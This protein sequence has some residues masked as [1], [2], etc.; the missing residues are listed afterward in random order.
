[1]ARRRAL[2]CLSEFLL[3]EIPISEYRRVFNAG[4]GFWGLQACATD[5]RA[6][7]FRR[8]PIYGIFCLA[9][10]DLSG[11]DLAGVDLAE[12]GAAPA[13]ANG[14]CG[15]R[16]INFSPAAA[17]LSSNSGTMM[18]WRLPFEPSIMVTIRLPGGADTGTASDIETSVTPAV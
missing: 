1:M 3:A 9:G 15:E 2:S 5:A 7:R 18:F 6:P 4:L 16:S 17:F 12:R 13:F 10:V 8:P 14:P 11:V